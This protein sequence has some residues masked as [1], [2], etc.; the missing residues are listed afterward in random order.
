MTKQEFV[1]R[2][3]DEAGIS[4]ADAARTLD[5]AI[6]VVEK[7][8]ARGGEI[9]LTG[10]GKFSVSKRAARQG[11]NPQTGQPIRIAAAKT[12]RF[13]AGAKLKQAVDGK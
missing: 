6:T 12:P 7:T 8:L 1:A 10:F 13:S 3:S 9:N 5:A 11:V 2:I 4:K